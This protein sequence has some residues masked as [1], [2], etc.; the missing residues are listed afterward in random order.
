MD[1][2]I[3]FNSPEIQR[4]SEA[5]P[6]TNAAVAQYVQPTHMY[7]NPPPQIPTGTV[8]RSLDHDAP[9]VASTSKYTATYISAT[10]CRPGMFVGAQARENQDALR[11]ELEESRDGPVA[12]LLDA[13]FPFPKHDGATAPNRDILKSLAKY[14]RKTPRPSALNNGQRK[15]LENG[16]TDI[17]HPR[18]HKSMLEARIIKAL[19]PIL[20]EIIS[21]RGLSDRRVT[22][23]RQ[24]NPI[25]TF[26]GGTLKPDIFLWGKGTPA[27]PDATGVPSPKTPTAAE[28]KVLSAEDKNAID[29]EPPVDWRWCIIPIEVKTEKSRHESKDQAM[30]QLGSYVR[31]VFAAQPHRRFVP[32]LMFTEST[33][34]FFL[35]DRAGVVFSDAFDYH[36]EAAHFCDIIGTIVSWNDEALG[37]D[38]N[39]QFQAGDRLRISTRS[40]A[41][42]VDTLAPLIT[43]MYN[44]RSHGSTCW[45][46]RRSNVS[47]EHTYLIHDTW[48][49]NWVDTHFVRQKFE[50]VRSRHRL[51]T[52]AEWVSFEPIQTSFTVSGLPPSQRF[53]DN[54]NSNRRL[55]GKSST[56]LDHGR[57]VWRYK[58]GECVPLE[59]YN[60]IPE[61][62]SAL[63]DVV[64]E[65]KILFLVCKM[66]HRDITLWNIYIHRGTNGESRGFLM[67]F[68]HAAYLDGPT[69]YPRSGIT[70]GSQVFMSR[71]ALGQRLPTH[72]DDLESVYYLLI[73]IVA[74]HTGPDTPRLGFTH[75]PQN[76]KYWMDNNHAAVSHSKNYHLDAEK[77]TIQVQD[78]FL[79][80]EPLTAKLRRFFG[81]CRNPA[82]MTDPRQDFQEFLGYFEETLQSMLRKRTHDDSNNSDGGDWARTPEGVGKNPWPDNKAPEDLERDG[83]RV[84]K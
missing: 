31:E 76:L 82:E 25:R 8:T 38:T 59:K 36:R 33:V 41:Y 6:G 26:A 42:M 75:L 66:M 11:F 27:F 37:F 3:D 5:T 60:S 55:V 73:W 69:I 70:P 77:S 67:D 17:P 9:V 54:V 40:G 28:R 1:Q 21:Y 48:S 56:S 4:T 34:E 43:Q 10:G 57:S 79:V 44:I 7:R 15:T 19:V 64:Q 29:Q 63:R 35:W 39:I 51:L 24:Q 84:K 14:Y 23:D 18:V 68:S 50:L 62:V 2:E 47:D 46:A 65:L 61:L 49:D 53:V 72:C 20:N 13:F 80:L 52:P 22:I 78:G 74:S 58:G 71:H 12:N 81:A 16:W 32:S 30:Y 83:R 45:R